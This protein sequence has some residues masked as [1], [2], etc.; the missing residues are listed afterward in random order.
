MP[1]GYPEYLG[2]TGYELL[3]SE[4]V[5]LGLA[6]HFVPSG[7]L[8][9]II[10]R[11]QNPPSRLS[12]EKTDALEQ[13]GKWIEPFTIQD[14]PAKPEMDEWVRTYLNGKDSLPGLLEDLRQC[15]LFSDLCQGIFHRLSERSPMALTVTLQLLRHNQGRPIEEVF[16]VDLKA[17]RFLL[18]H[19]DYLEG[20]R[21][22]LI[23]KDDRPWWR[24]DRIEEVGEIRLDPS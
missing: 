24:P 5:R 16:Q 4:S 3:G 8:P 18:N 19:P 2:L 15:T 20:V 11:L 7:D 14:I 21:A 1:A 17:S 13:I 22:R 6:T 9:G 12:R 10:E 23:D